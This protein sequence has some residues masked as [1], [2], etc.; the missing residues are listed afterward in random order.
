MPFGQRKKA[1][2]VRESCKK[3]QNSSKKLPLSEAEK[4][5]YVQVT[6]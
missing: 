1:V 2:D 3:H 5:P 6:L 4:H